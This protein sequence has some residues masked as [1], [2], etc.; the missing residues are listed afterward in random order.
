M[1]LRFYL[2]RNEKYVRFVKHFY[3][4]KTEEGYYSK[5][6]VVSGNVRVIF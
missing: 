3:S 6:L 5:N 2:A 4:F 1:G